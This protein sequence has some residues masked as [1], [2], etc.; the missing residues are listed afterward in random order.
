MR[1]QAIDGQPTSDGGGEP[2]GNER[3]RIADLTCYESASAAVVD[4][5]AEAAGVE[6]TDLRP[7]FEFV[8]PDA[9]DSLAADATVRFRYAGYSVTVST[10]EVVVRAPG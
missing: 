5:V 1:R 6:P 9:L 3:A 10:D 8:D 4:A 2:D 7:L